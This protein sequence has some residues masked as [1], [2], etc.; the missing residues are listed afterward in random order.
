MVSDSLEMRETRL[1]IPTEGGYT[2]YDK[3][4]DILVVQVKRGIDEEN[5]TEMR[6]IFS[7]EGDSESM[8]LAA[9]SSNNIK[10]YYFNVSNILGI[11]KS[12]KVAPI[13]QDGN[14]ET[15][16]KVTFETDIPESPIRDIPAI[17]I[18]IG[19]SPTTTPDTSAKY[20]WSFDTTRTDSINSLAPDNIMGTILDS[21]NFN[22]GLILDGNNDYVDYG[23]SANLLFD[24]SKFTIS[25]WV[26]REVLEETGIIMS[27]TDSNGANPDDMFKIIIQPGTT[28]PV[29]NITISDGTTSPSLASSIEIDNNWHHA[30]FTYDFIASDLSIY[31]DGNLDNTISSNID[32]QSSNLDLIFG[33]QKTSNDCNLDENAFNGAIDEV[34]IFDKA[35]LAA[36]A[37]K[38]ESRKYSFTPGFNWVD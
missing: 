10:T 15:E 26:K 36:E 24:S 29:L 16:G 37:T 30:V 19:D 23:N 18:M 5:V 34:I 20:Y 21:A 25:F 2:F 14:K 13:F 11:P 33:C 12:V 27:I 32:I 4:K 7:F 28:N 1:Y 8:V 22:N 38:L 9:P 17:L 3:E 6:L 31:I 35:L